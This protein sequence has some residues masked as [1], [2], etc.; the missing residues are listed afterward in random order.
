MEGTLT[1]NSKKVKAFITHFLHYEDLCSINYSKK[2]KKTWPRV[3]IDQIR[4]LPKHQTKK[5][6]QRSKLSS[7]QVE[8]PSPRVDTVKSDAKT[9]TSNKEKKRKKKKTKKQ[10]SHHQSLIQCKRCEIPCYYQQIKYINSSNVKNTFGFLW[11]KLRKRSG[12]SVWLAHE[13]LRD[14]DMATWVS[15]AQI[16][17]IVREEVRAV[18]DSFS[19]W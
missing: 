17:E 19:L 14:R 15:W 3:S 9:Q 16:D 12:R 11:K 6:K 5:K 2:K 1:T 18:R 10:T 8:N 7:P 13:A 4:C